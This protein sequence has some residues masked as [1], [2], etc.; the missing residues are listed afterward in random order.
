MELIHIEEQRYA[1]FIHRG[2]LKDLAITN[3]YIWGIWLPQSGYEIAHASD[4]EVYPG[5]FKPDRTDIPIEI[6]VPLERQP[7]LKR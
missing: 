1:I 6:W 3:Q 4:L 7:Q 2:G 5:D